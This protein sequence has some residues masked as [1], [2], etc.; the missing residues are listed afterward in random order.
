MAVERERRWEGRVDWDGC[1]SERAVE[2]F[3]L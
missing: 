2:E 3:E 1:A